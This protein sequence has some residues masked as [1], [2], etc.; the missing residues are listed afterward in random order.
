[1]YFVLSMLIVDEYCSNSSLF[2]SDYGVYFND[3]D[4]LNDTLGKNMFR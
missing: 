2:Y 4:T 3:S 1:M